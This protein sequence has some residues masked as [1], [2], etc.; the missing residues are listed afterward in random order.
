MPVNDMN[1]SCHIKP[2]N[3]YITPHHATIV[4][5]S[6]RGGDTQTHTHT[7]VHTETSPFNPHKSFFKC[8]INVYIAYVI[9]NVRW[10]LACLI[11]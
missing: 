6:L 5:N 4:I 1:Y 9:K 8:F 3:L 11:L 7:D 2:Y 10:L